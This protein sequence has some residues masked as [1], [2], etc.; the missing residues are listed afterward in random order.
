MQQLV[1]TQLH[2]RDPHCFLIHRE[3]LQIEPFNV[4]SPFWIE[5]HALVAHTH[6]KRLVLGVSIKHMRAITRAKPAVFIRRYAVFL[7]RFYEC[8][9]VI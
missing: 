6:W 9:D 4:V 8:T 5:S 2:P 7:K 1:F 3:T